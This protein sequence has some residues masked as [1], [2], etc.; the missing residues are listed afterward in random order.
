VRLI[1]ARGGDTRA[2]TR[3]ALSLN[4]A[5]PPVDAGGCAL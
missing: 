1:N 2:V 5:P 3:I 4:D